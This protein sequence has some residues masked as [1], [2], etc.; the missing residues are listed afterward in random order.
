MQERGPG[1][2]RAVAVGRDVQIGEEGAQ[3]V[4]RPRDRPQRRHRTVI[5]RPVHRRAQRLKEP[6]GDHVGGGLRGQKRGVGIAQRRAVKR[7]ELHLGQVG[8]QPRHQRREAVG[9]RQE[10]RG[11][12]QVEA[13]VKEQKR[14]RCVGQPIQRGHSIGEDPQKRQR[15]SRH[16]HVEK[17][18]RHRHLPH[19]PRPAD[20][21]EQRGERGA[22]V[23]A[24][25][26]RR[27]LHQ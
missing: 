6:R 13:R 21:G 26:D 18:V 17:H 2:T 23:H 27:A 11:A 22:H 14:R 25:D 3:F 24:D 9:Q 16:D 4:E 5:G 1:F 15:Q 10:E 19:R 12:H 8:H 7:D 20:R